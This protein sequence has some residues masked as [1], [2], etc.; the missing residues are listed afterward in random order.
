MNLKKITKPQSMFKQTVIKSDNLNSNFKDMLS[1]FLDEKAMKSLDIGSNLSKTQKKALELFEQGKSLFILGPA[2]TGKSLLLKTMQEYNSENIKKNFVLTST[3][4]ISAYSIG[5]MTI[6]SFMG[7]GTGDK[8]EKYLLKRI[9]KNKPTVERLRETDILVIDE[10]SMLSA[11][12]FEKINLILQNIR[13]CKEF[14]GGIQVI[15]TG[16]VLQLECVF[17]RNVLLYDNQPEDTR[18]IIE[19]EQFLNKFN[20]KNKNIVVLSE[21]FRQ[22]NDTKFMEMLLRIRQKKHTDNDVALLKS[23]CLE[24]PTAEIKSQ[25]I[26]L[27]SS[28]KKAQII[29]DSNVLKIKQPEITFVASFEVLGQ[30]KD[31]CDILEKELHTQF[32]QK[33]IVEIKFKKT[34]R[35]MLIKNLDTSLGL[36]NGSIGTIVDFTPNSC[37]IVLF[38][39]GVRKIIEKSEWELEM[40]DNIVKASQIPLIL[41]YSITIHKSQSL[42]LDCA[43]L[44][45][46][47]CFCNHMVY[48]ALSR[49]KSFDGLYLKS[50]NSK[51][52]SVNNKMIEYLK[53]II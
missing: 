51:K 49:V 4:G 37:P 27:V 26:H 18:L 38:D 15:F 3:T 5:G 47:D 1:E 28:N 39:N 53:S 17:N 9:L 43:V 14:F 12:L 44:D 31:T 36:I 35:V 16:D 11:S 21:N 24:F 45:L 34:C 50:F 42:T 25:P 32:K 19:S 52:I 46:A 29:N 30:D 41:A 22:Q 23:K 2:G 10:I 7:F 40:H 6:H 8:E 48:V 13:K 20:K 33:G